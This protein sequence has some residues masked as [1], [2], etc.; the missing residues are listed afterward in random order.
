MLCLG[1]D[2][3][4]YFGAHILHMN[5]IQHAGKL[6]FNFEMKARKP[7][8]TTIESQVEKRMI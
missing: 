1:I 8:L 6:F 2:S 5:Q 7:V 3:T 4:K